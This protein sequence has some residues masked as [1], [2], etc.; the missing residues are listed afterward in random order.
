MTYSVP[1]VSSKLS[2]AFN[3]SMDL[4]AW[5]FAR[6]LVY[7]EPFR[8]GVLG[9]SVLSGKD[10]CY[11]TTYAPGVERDLKILVNGVIDIEVRNSA[12]N[13][14]GPAMY[15]S[16]VCADAL[17]KLDELDSMHMYWNMGP[18]VSTFLILD[19]YYSAL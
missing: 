9:T 18:Q 13:G 14:D 7:K 17:F 4:Y 16:M 12:Q 1:G 10:N 6:K 8:I 19:F 5:K 15:S 11:D 3:E 2:A